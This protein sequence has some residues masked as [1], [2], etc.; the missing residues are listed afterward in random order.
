MAFTYSEALTTDRDKVRFRIGDT[1]LDVGPRPDKRNF[2]DAEITFVISEE[3]DQV[4]GAIAHCFEIL[5]SEWSSYA[6]SEKE[7]EVQF[8]AKEVAENYR[9]QAEDWRE[10]PG[11]GDEAERSASLITLQ[12]T[13]PYTSITEWA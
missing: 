12:R 13:D 1:Q 11:G 7:G 2:S 9:K 8:D 4:N 3:S 5:A 10:K 6:L